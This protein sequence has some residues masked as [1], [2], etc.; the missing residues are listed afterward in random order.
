MTISCKK[1][2]I[3]TLLYLSVLATITVVL[4]WSVSLH[5]CYYLDPVNLNFTGTEIVTVSA[6]TTIGPKRYLSY[7]PPGNGWNN[8]RIALE[9]AILLAKLLN[10]TL[11]VHPLSSHSTGEDMKKVFAP[12]KRFGHVAY[13]KM[14]QYN[15]LPLSSFLDMK[16][17]SEIVS[18]IE[19]NRTHAEFIEEYSDLRWHRVCHS[20]G[21]GYWADRRPRTNRERQIWDK[22]LF[23][24]PSL[25]FWMGKCKVEI[26]EAKHT[27]V[28]VKVIS[29]FNDD[30][31]DLLYI[32]EGTLF[33]IEF[34]FMSISDTLRAQD[35]I[36]NNIR[37]NKAVYDRARVVRQ[38]LGPYNAIHVRRVNHMGSQTSQHTWITK[39]MDE[40]F[41]TSTPLY[42]ATDEPQLT[43]FK[44]FEKA[45]YKLYFAR[46][47]NS[48]LNFSHIHDS[49]RQD[50]LGIHEQVICELADKF[51][52]TEHSTFS[53]FVKRIRRE[54]DSKDGLYSEGFHSFW[55]GHML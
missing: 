30:D 29:D 18:I 46:D 22:Q 1:S 28:I 52:P 36:M 5:C 13:N 42:I 4:F 15:L 39:L 44:P 38:T 43:W 41:L 51:L 9:G 40:D 3:L 32:E 10:R 24:S 14:H 17:L 35:I 31:S 37:Y 53:R 50:Y 21:Y 7:Q 26:E 48:M 20:A 8:Q 55:M 27:K 23:I 19:Y 11:I 25:T 16:L 49:V 2:N 12:D 34:R 6:A 33:G 45:G 54:F 47:F